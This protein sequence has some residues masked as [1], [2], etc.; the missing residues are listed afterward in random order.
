MTWVVAGVAL[1]L[2]T[3][4]VWSR[5]AARR[6]LLARIRA[7]WGQPLERPRPF[8]DIADLYR[9][10]IAPESSLDD[11]TWNDLLLDDLFR[12]LDRTRSTVGQQ[13]L[14][15]R[16]RHS[17]MAPHREAFE[18]LVT[19]FT[20]DPAL[21]E[22]TQ[23][24]LAALSDGAGY[25][26]HRLG[27]TVSRRPW[28][29]IFPLIGIGM[30][31][32]VVLLAFWPQLLLVVVAGSVV[33]LMVRRATARR[34]RVEIPA[35]RQVGPLLSAAKTL[36]MFDLPG[37]QPIVDH[38]TADLRALRRV[39]SI[40]RWV[41][42]D[43]LATDDLTM[44]LMEYLNLLFLMDANALYFASWDLEK[45]GARLVRVVQTVGEIDAAIAVASWRA[46]LSSNEWTRPVFVED[47]ARAE[48]EDLRH[49]LVQRA[50]PNSISLAPPHGVLITGSNM[51]GKSTFLRAIGVN[52]VLA[53]TINTCLATT[54]RAPIYTVQTC[55]GRS[56]DLLA[57]KSYYLVEVES[58]LRLVRAS[59]RIGPQLFIFD[60]L[61]RGTNAVERMAPRWTP[62]T[63]H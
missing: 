52:S 33:N 45:H 58:V 43:P 25:Y 16:L 50:V 21:R 42:R 24:A 53:Q 17:P 8:D 38:L 18:A 55:I 9:E 15:A 30:L 5:W 34:V 6:R 56:D 2:F 19:A 12:V 57:G 23:Y 62:K 29:V 35:F 49:P 28:H 31:V 36:T 48:L 54:Y 22:Q 27:Q 4:W 20:A 1:A 11:R 10:T 3:Y 26:V 14:Y 37:E 41:S 46:G 63:G 39:R 13:A 7:E 61:F 32:A 59:E 51:S 60:E 40:A 47:G 44:A